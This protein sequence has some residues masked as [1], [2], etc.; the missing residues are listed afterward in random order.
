L[1][2]IRLLSWAIVAFVLLFAATGPWQLS[3]VS[4]SRISA[5]LGG[6]LSLAI[7][8]LAIS[9][10][11]RIAAARDFLREDFYVSPRLVA[12][13]GAATALLVFLVIR[14]RYLGFEVNAW[15][16]SFYDRSLADP[17]AGGFLFNEIENRSVLGTHA[18]LLLLLFL[19][20]YAVLPSPYWLLGGQA[21]LVGLA[22]VAGFYCLRR[23]VR[24]DFTAALLCAA[25]VL[26][27]Y[28]ARAVQYVFH[29]E[30]FYPTSLFLLMYGFLSQRLIPIAFGLGATAA[31]KEDAV[32]PLIGFA[33][34]ASVYYRRHRWAAAAA[35]VG[36]A[37]FLI[38]YF[39]IIPY[40][41]GQHGA[42]WYSH[43][44]A[45]YGPTPPA[46]L[47]GM[48]RHP[49]ELIRDL[50]GSGF[51][52][53]T[54]T[55]ALIPLVGYELLLAAAP[56]IVSYSAAAG[57][58][59]SQLRLYYS[60]PLLPFVF[61]AAARGL[62]RLGSLGKNTS[63]ARARAVC[64]VGA[65]AILLSSAMIGPGY[66][67]VSRQ[68][69]D[70]PTRLARAAIGRPLL[71]QGALLPHVGYS[72]DSSV[73]QPPVTIDGRHGFLIAPNVRPY[74]FT[75]AEL[76]GLLQQLSSDPR[77]RV[78]ADRGVMLFAPAAWATLTHEQPRRMKAEK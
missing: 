29:P 55:L 4:I 26:N 74:P 6:A 57:T 46:A 67:L 59:L 14:N 40:F 53:L 24:D 21:L 52:P 28:T 71:V 27:P 15:D 49:A 43:Y 65:L 38:D 1:P 54:A 9:A 37:V 73:L 64:R 60:L 77:F 41:S 33:I 5:A 35:S 51:W 42:P 31:V 76:R 22:V 50:I 39:G 78:T 34:V 20:F 10:K 2:V 63:P 68:A 61:L 30:I 3:G 23:L 48:A 36:L 56:M 32:L 58:Q 66:R 13:G 16:F 8:W 69:T 11:S 25:F 45:K 7:L 72:S 17:F 12:V 44:W 75:R 62:E 19:P 70:V 47:L 18:Y